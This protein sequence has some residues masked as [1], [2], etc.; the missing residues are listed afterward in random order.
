MESQD[1]ATAFT[2]S[3]LE[4]LERHLKVTWNEEETPFCVVDWIDEDSIERLREDLGMLMRNDLALEARH[5]TAKYGAKRVQTVGF[6]LAPDFDQFVKLGL[7][8]GD[9]VVLW[10]VIHS[11]ILGNEKSNVNRNGLLAQ[12]ACNLLMFRSVVRRGALV[13]LPHPITWSS[14]AVAIDADMRACGPV[15]AASLGLAMAFAAIE[16]GLPLHPYGL[17]ESSSM[18]ASVT[19]VGGRADEMFSLESFRFQQCVIRLMRDERFT[20]LEDVRPEEFLNVISKH[21]KFRNG[22]R[23]HFA[24]ALGGLSAQQAAEEADNRVDDLFELFKKRNSD[25]D[26]YIAEGVDAT[27]NFL[28]MSAS[29]VVLGQPL[30][31]TLSA[32]GGPALHLMA[33]IRKWSKTPE[34]NAIVQVFKALDQTS[35]TTEKIS[36]HDM[37]YQVSNYCRG[38]AVLGNVFE[39]FMSFHWAEER[40]GY[41]QSLPAEVAR[42]LLALLTP[43]CLE[44]IVNHRRFQEDY[45]GDYLAYL[46]ELDE[47]IYWEHLGKT[48]ESP[49]GLLIYDDDANVVSMETMKMPSRTW[50]QLLNSLFEAYADEVRS[51]SYGYPLER[52]P[53]IIRFQTEA[54]EDATAK[55]E[56]LISLAL[57]LGLDDRVALSRL[58]ST[59]YDGVVPQWFLV[60]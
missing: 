41:L 36:L 52:F 12:I 44:V 53:A 32:I 38:Q 20:Y 25:V 6:G 10:D 5:A 8:Y 59:A 60:V 15:P 11:R 4:L 26:Q 19:E 16:E 29:L 2:L 50:A 28:L 54:G 1:A 21:T 51:Q 13:I 42:A 23:M 33:A 37:E 46:S 58:V 39:E 30:L 18:P 17:L 14:L 49:D 22:L 35:N 43:D 27:G 56:A 55:R 40:L 47:A 34:K 3:Y 57:S 48:F 24:S 31:A 7:I 9:R 45:I